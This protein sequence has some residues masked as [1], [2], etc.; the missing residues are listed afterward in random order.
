MYSLRIAELRYSKPYCT[1]VSFQKEVFTLRKKFFLI[2][3]VFYNFLFSALTNVKA[4]YYTCW[5]RDG[6]SFWIVERE[7]AALFVS[8]LLSASRTFAPGRYVRTYNCYF[9]KSY[10]VT[11]LEIA[12]VHFSVFRYDIYSDSIKL[13]EPK[14]EMVQ[15][16]QKVYIPLKK[17]PEVSW[18]FP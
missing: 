16:Q 7:E 8:E 1:I 9:C 3:T 4:D 14:G 15:L 12:R 13:P 10:V 6:L 2:W 18:D 17:H 5:N 11:F